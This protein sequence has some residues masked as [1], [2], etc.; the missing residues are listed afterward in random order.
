VS[1]HRRHSKIVSAAPVS[2]SHGWVRPRVDITILVRTNWG[3]IIGLELDWYDT[4][5]EA[6]DKIEEREGVP[7]RQQRIIWAGK[8]LED[9]SAFSSYNI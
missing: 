3:K 1:S 9:E 8:Q 4:V 7:P 2:T 6:K 5:Q